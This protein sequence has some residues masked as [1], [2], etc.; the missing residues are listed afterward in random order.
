MF[1]NI[2]ETR[3]PITLDKEYV[4]FFNANTMC[5]FEEATGKNFLATVAALYEAY[6]PLLD[7]QKAGATVTPAVA[8][9]DV[10][11]HVPIADLTALIW[12][13]L[14]TYDANDMPTWPLTLGHV[15]RLINM[16]TIPKLFL[17]FLKGQSANSPTEAEMGE[18]PAQSETTAAPTPP[19]STA[20]PQAI[21]GGERSIALP[22]DAF[23]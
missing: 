21:N 1:N 5:A 9:G 10:I 3:I 23:T 4:L 17:S 6:K 22:E 11:R 15:R 20:S 12:A 14:H 8:A 18:S 2:A 16:T 13:G 19:S 7:A